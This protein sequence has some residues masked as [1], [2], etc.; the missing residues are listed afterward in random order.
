MNFKVQPWKPATAYTVGQQV[1]DSHFQIQ[2][3]TTLGTSRTALQGPPVWSAILGAVT[4]DNTV[5]WRDQGPQVAAHAIW[6]ASHPYTSGTGTEIVDSNNNIQLVTTSGTSRT[7]L[8][9]HPAWSPTPG[10][11]TADNTVRWRN[12]GSAATANLA[13]AGGTSGIIIDNIVGTGTMAGASQ[14]YF[15]TQ[16]NQATCGGG[17]GGCAVQASQS[18]LQ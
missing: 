2:V 6:L 8:Q 17:P 14:V 7:A 18:A 11:I 9:G 10:V 15:S 13:A 4:A 5:R 1:I 16:G 3:V 12:L